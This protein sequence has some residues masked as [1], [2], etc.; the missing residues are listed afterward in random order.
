MS[1]TEPPPP[2]AAP[3]SRFGNLA[4]L[5]C[6]ALALA[7]GGMAWWLKGRSEQAE[8]DRLSSIREYDLMR[9]MKKRISENEAR[10]P[11][12]GTE[13]VDVSQL[14]TFID[15][16]ATAAGLGSRRFSN[17]PV[18]KTGSWTEHA[19]T[20]TFES[21]GGKGASIPRGPFVDFL[22]SIERER[23]YLKSKALTLRFDGQDLAAATVTIS[24]FKR[25]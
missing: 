8:R 5:V 19:V 14:T 18:S 9:A 17:V 23:P 21:A 25:D 13:Q 6:A 3:P 2:A 15:S 20:V 11:K 4:L 22:A 16:K 24:Y 1:K 7:A 10:T 12:G